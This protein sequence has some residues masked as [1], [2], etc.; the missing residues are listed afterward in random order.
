MSP[1]PSI[2]RPGSSPVQPMTGRGSC[3]VRSGEVLGDGDHHLGAEDPE[4]VVHEEA[5]QEEAADHVRAERLISIP[6]IENAAPSR[7]LRYHADASARTRPTRGA[8]RED[9]D[10]VQREREHERLA[11][12]RR[13][14]V[15]ASGS[16]SRSRSADEAEVGERLRRP[17]AAPRP[18]RGCQ[19]WARD[20]VV[21]DHRSLFVKSPRGKY[22][23]KS[24]AGRTAARCIHG[25]LID[26][27]SAACGPGHA[28]RI[29]APS[30]AA[31]YSSI[32]GSALAAE[33]TIGEP[34][35][36]AIIL[37][38]LQGVVDEDVVRAR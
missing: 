32:D 31:K 23:P 11:L 38:Q 6:W 4:D 36:P 19:D 33:S 22:R 7:L 30:I 20:L 25:N 28:R 14:P 17:R 12:L 35:G 34:S 29:E 10:V 37:A 21:A 8:Q 2:D 16:G 5:A 27:P 24:S 13:L 26:K 15:A 9:A 18:T 3:V 1:R